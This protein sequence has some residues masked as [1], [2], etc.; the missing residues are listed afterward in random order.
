M[1]Q[2]L[3]SLRGVPDDEA[4]DIRE[5]LTVNNI[6]YYETPP[7]NWGIS[8]PAIWLKKKD[9]QELAEFLLKEY[10]EKR[11]L[12]QRMRYQ[13][14]VRTGKAPT[15]IN[16]LK[17]KPSLFALYLC[18]IGLVLYLSMKLVLEISS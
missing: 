5:L 14:L 2:L 1:T 16:N 13:Q 17:Q 11:S 6:D 8:M 4:E 15:L 3:F 10:Q 9:Q 12:V 18:G 7:G